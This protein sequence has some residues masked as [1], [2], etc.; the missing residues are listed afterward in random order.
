[1]SKDEDAVSKSSEQFY[2][3]VNR[4]INGDSRALSDVWSHGAEVTAMHPIGGR[5]IGWDNVRQSFEQVAQIATE[6][7]VTLVDQVIQV[8]GDLAYEVG[9]ERGQ[10]TLAGTQVG[11]DFRV[12]NIYRRER[13]E[14]K[15]VHHHT[16]VSPAMVEAIHH[17]SVKA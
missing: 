10:A 3:A 1:M 5:M 15:I 7:K 6:G 11:L 17:S 8:E 4:M 14:W 2:S 9:V 12:T 16:D 13:G